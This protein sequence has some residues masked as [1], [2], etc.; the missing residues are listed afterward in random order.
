MDYQ[1]T[2][3]SI[4]YDFLDQVDYTPRTEEEE[5]EDEFEFHEWWDEVEGYDT[6]HSIVDA[7]VTCGW[8]KHLEIILAADS[9]PDQI[10]DGLWH[11]VEDWKQINTCMAFELLRT[12]A[13]EWIQSHVE[14]NEPMFESDG[15]LPETNDRQIWL[16]KDAPL[17]IIEVEKP[18]DPLT[19]VD[20]LVVDAGGLLKLDFWVGMLVFEG[21]PEQAEPRDLKELALGGRKAV[22]PRRLYTQKSSRNSGDPP[23]PQE[24]LSLALGKGW[25]TIPDYDHYKTVLPQLSVN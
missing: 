22:R 5:E 25:V 24:A 19:S 14:G 11:G 18:A 8:R 16:G 23:T 13:Q 9:D 2:I 7:Y 1:E 21:D 12:D 10:D 20:V 17:F 3:H 4:A 6:M 15:V